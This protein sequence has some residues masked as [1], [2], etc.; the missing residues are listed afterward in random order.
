MFDTGSL[1][2]LLGQGRRVAVK[3]GAGW[4]SM[5]DDLDREVLAT[6]AGRAVFEGV[7][8]CGV[9]FD[10][11]PELVRRL[12]ILELPTVVVLGPDGLEVGRVV[13]FSDPGSWIAEAREAVVA[14]DPVPAMRE[15]AAAG[16]PRAMLAL[17]EA[18][19]SRAPDEGVAWL[20]RVSWGDDDLAMHALWVLG[21]YYH[22]VCADPRTARLVWQQ[23]ALRW[24]DQHSLQAVWWYGKA[25][26]ELGR[27]DLG[28]RASEAWAELCPGD[29][30]PI[31]D[32]AIYA[33]R[34]GYDAARP[35]IRA[36]ASAAAER[37]RGDDRD[38][39][40]EL[41]MNLSKPF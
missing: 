8:T 32:W 5:C 10:A 6:E 24:P 12:A 22:R 30:R 29:A 33:G 11:A 27:V 15:G 25:Q 28:S 7:A 20:E 17:G 18:L 23:L 13:G 31:T 2:E 37:A 34:H 26:A 9:D 35:A 41:V 19:L 16:E 36:A 3:L 38:Q 21:R 14:D 40:E 1:D 4:C 39:L